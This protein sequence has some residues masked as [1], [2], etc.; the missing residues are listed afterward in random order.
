VPAWRRP[1]LGA[2]LAAG[3][4]AGCAEW[5]VE[6]YVSYGGLGERLRL[7][8]EI[9]GGTGP[10]FAVDDQVRALAGRGLCRPCDIPWQHRDTAVWFFALPP[11][12]ALGAVAAARGRHRAAAWLPLPVAALMAVPYLFLI[13]YAAPR[14]LLPSYA[15]LAVPVAFAGRALAVDRGGR[16]RPLPTALLVVALCAHLFV[17]F[18]VT[19]RVTG[20]NRTMRHALTTAAERLH[21]AGVRP[22]CELSGDS[23]VVIA[24]YAGCSSREIGGPDTSTTPAALTAAARRTPTAFLVGPR[25]RPPAF[26]RTW[27]P[28]PLGAVGTATQHVAY[29]APLPV[30]D[31]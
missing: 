22:P 28:V 14:F 27:H 12:A 30:G 16:W 19:T 23:S 25:G 4:L 5:V 7:A 13:G 17:Q 29:V 2:A 8:S 9:Q 10:H 15:L 6:A 20:S 3:L 1:T 18:T 26:A 11:L 21:A 31:R 24:F